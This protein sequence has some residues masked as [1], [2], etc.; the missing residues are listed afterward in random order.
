[1]QLIEINLISAQELK[2]ISTD[3]QTFAVLWIDPKVKLIS[4]I[5]VTGHMNPTWNDKFIFHL[6]DQTLHNPNSTLVIEIYAAR[7]F[8]KDKKIGIV[9]IFLDNLIAS[10]NRFHEGVQGS[11][12][13]YQVRRPS[14]KPQGIVNIGVIYLDERRDKNVINESVMLSSA[15]GHRELLGK[16]NSKVTCCVGCLKIASNL[17]PKERKPRKIYHMGSRNKGKVLELII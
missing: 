12:Q 6:Q 14:G 15:I 1:M 5:D 3:M 7:C 2:G 11:F 8:L 16:S 9:R 4:G 13:A 17:M 10:S